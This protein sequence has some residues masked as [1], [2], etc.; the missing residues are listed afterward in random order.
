[1]AQDELFPDA[2]GHCGAGDADLREGAQSG[3]W[4]ELSGVENAGSISLG[5]SWRS[6]AGGLLR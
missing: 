4:D 5:G 2:E 1:M 3:E 6:G